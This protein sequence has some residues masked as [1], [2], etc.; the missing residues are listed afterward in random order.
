MSL[1]RVYFAH[2]IT[3]Y[4]SAEEA[5]ALARLKSEGLD[6]T[7]PSD[8]HHQDAC[9]SDMVRW[10]ALAGSCDGVAFMPF[11]DGAIGAGVVKEVNTLWAQNKPV[12][13]LTPD[14][15]TLS[16]VSDWPGARTLL[17]VDETRERLKEFREQRVAQGLTPVPVRDPNAG[18]PRP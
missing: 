12:F 14:G 11:P 15:N 3:A 5:C 13:E 1:P 8:R 18:A 7:N 17:T 6:V 4:C 16:A 2:P 9:G 10:A